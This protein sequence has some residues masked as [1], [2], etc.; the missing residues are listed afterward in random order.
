MAMDN[1][2]LRLATLL[3]QS[4]GSQ[5]TR[6]YI[7]T[8]IEMWK[9]W[10]VLSDDSATSNNYIDDAR[11]RVYLL[12]AGQLD[13]PTLRLNEFHWL[14][15]LAVHLCFNVDTKCGSNGSIRHAL[16]SYRN[17]VL[18]ADGRAAPPRPWY[19]TIADANNRLK[20][21]TALVLVQEG[22]GE[23][24]EVPAADDATSGN[25]PE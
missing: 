3:S 8:Q 15:A 4:V 24:M 11:R 1:G 7:L 6:D 20:N 19:D 17:A 21:S 10:G 16:V 13:D 5:V 23:N 9:K 25:S 2:D 12:M 18:S 22:N 14:Q